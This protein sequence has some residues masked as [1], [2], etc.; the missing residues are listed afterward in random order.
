MKLRPIRIREEA[1]AELLH[2]VRFYESSRKGQG[3]LFREAVNAA[4]QLIRR[5]PTAGTAGP[6]G[7]KKAKVKGFPFTV[8]YRNDTDAVVVFAI[9]A[10][11]RQE[12]YWLSRSQ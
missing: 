9:A 6:G 10:D 2:E 1:R 5:F 3:K 7:T 11:S 8:V 12:G 4:A